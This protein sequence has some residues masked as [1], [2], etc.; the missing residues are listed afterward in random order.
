V[1]SARTGVFTVSQF[2]AV[3]DLDR[4]QAREFVEGFVEAGI[5]ERTVGGLRLTPN[6]YRLVRDFSLSWSSAASEM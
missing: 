5:I 6:G 4:E 1:R 3:A 2:A